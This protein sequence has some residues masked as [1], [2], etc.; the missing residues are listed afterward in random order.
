M[1]SSRS[2]KKCE[3]PD[4]RPGRS[5]TASLALVLGPVRPAPTTR[6]EGYASRAV[7]ARA[8]ASLARRRQLRSRENQFRSHAATPPA[9]DRSSLLRWAT[10]TLSIG[11][12]SMDRG[13]ARA[14]AQ[15]PSRCAPAANSSEGRG[16]ARAP[17]RHDR[18]TRT[19][20]LSASR[21]CVARSPTW[22]SGRAR[23]PAAGI[24]EARMPQEQRARVTHR[25]VAAMKISRV[26]ARKRSRHTPSASL[27]KQRSTRT[28]G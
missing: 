11:R 22:P 24:A 3:P 25:A 23:C 19:S 13:A 5:P 1:N 26:R 4:S 2:W 8:P 12:G 9:G 14:T 16:S 10:L 27:V 20:A 15:I 7:A 18:L 28:S 17:P 6:V 21:R